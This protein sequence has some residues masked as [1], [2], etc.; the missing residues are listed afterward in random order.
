M[1]RSEVK[2]GRIYETR[3]YGLVM[4]LED[5]RAKV[6]ARRMVGGAVLMDGLPEIGR[7]HV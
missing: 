1:K 6:M 2:A 4:A 7:A 3:R 5:G